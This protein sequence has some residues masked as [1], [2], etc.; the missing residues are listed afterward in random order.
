MQAALVVCVG[1]VVKMMMRK[2]KKRKKK[3]KKEN[4][5]TQMYVEYQTETE[6]WE[7]KSSLLICQSRVPI[8]FPNTK[9]QTPNPA[10]T[11]ANPTLTQAATLT[12]EL[13]GAVFCRCFG[14]GHN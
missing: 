4:N 10:Q 3:E 12:P 5:F 14:V 8:P 13:P 1:S 7:T 9:H 2:E 11:V 6:R